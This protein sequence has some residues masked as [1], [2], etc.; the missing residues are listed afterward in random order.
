MPATDSSLLSLLGTPLEVTSFLRTATMRDTNSSFLDY[1]GTSLMAA[2]LTRRHRCAVR[3]T[4]STLHD[5]V[6]TSLEGANIDI[7]LCSMCF[8][9]SSARGFIDTSVKAATFSCRLY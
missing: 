7:F 2:L 8:T 6:G 1:I 9:N 4:H 5:L 3:D